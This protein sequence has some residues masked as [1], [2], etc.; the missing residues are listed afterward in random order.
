M[1]KRQK[2]FSLVELLIVVAIILIIVAIAVPDLLKMTMKGRETSGAASVRQI[3]NC[4]VSYQSGHPDI[5][6]P[7][8]GADMG[9]AGD[10]CLDAVLTGALTGGAPKSG[11]V[12][13]YAPTNPVGGVNTGFTLTGAPASCDR[14][15][16]RTYFADESAV[17][18]FTNAAGCPQ[19][20]VT[21]P[22]L[23]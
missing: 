21:S 5:G 15:G 7:A 1:N 20:D 10:G 18:R 11:Y 4:A 23:S 12:F 17:V 6:Y 19:A 13:T 16:R 2:G 22:P 3:I 14:T 8:A 9:P